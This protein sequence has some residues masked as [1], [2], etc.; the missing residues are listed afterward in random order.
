MSLPKS[1]LIENVVFSIQNVSNKSNDFSV[2]EIYKSL[3]TTVE[4]VH[5]REKQMSEN[6]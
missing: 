2:K 1:Y 5:I 4:E 6:M 3:D